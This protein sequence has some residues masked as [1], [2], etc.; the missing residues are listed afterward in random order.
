MYKQK[1]NWRIFLTL[2]IVIFAAFVLPGCTNKTLRQPSVSES[3]LFKK[4]RVLLSGAE[5][6]K[7]KPDSLFKEAYEIKLIQ[8][9][10]HQ[11][12][13]GKEFAQRIYLSH[14]DFSRPVI[15]VTE[16]YS[17]PRNRTSELSK[18][19]GANQIR[20][21]HRFFGE[22]R[23]DS[24]EWKYLNV[25]QIASDYHRI[26]QLFKKIYKGKWLSTG[27]SKGGQTALFFRR[28]YPSDV[29]VTV[30][31]VAPMNFAQEDPRID[32]FIRNNGSQECS[33]KIKNY[34]IMLLKNRDKIIPLFAKYAKKKKW[35][36]SI[37]FDVTFE[38]GVLEYPFTFWQWGNSNC[39]SIPRAGASPEELFKHFVKVIPFKSYYSDESIK[40]SEP[41]FYQFFTELGYY[42]YDYNP[43]EVKKLLKA[44]PH[45]TN[46][47]F[48]P[49]GVSLKFKP[50][51]MKDINDWLQNYGNNIIYI[52]GG[53]DPWSATGVVL[54]G[55]TNA[56]KIVKKN[57]NHR[58][59]IRNLSIEDREKV[60]FTLEKW[61]LK[62][63]KANMKM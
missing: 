14:I 30:A 39:D 26:V 36:F 49:K 54:K 18:I 56:L 10:D 13:E 17:M 8:P 12:P 33:E 47:F 4:L 42:D 1:T 51:V 48:V 41:A 25:K 6:K 52:Y 23:P 15:F 59:R 34:Q 43:P 29:D 45:P 2:F 37:G 61:G 16:G 44:V 32:R 19:L 11:N 38:Y 53:L 57:G 58:T 46:A 63:Q 31:Y 60:L 5:I 62:I 50:E 7:I 9:L 24:M 21:E 3:P 35:H 28:F 55:K 27:I 20:V 40:S 22:S